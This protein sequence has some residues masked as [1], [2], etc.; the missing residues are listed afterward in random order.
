VAFGDPP[1]CDQCREPSAVRIVTIVFEGLSPPD[2]YL[3]RAHAPNVEAPVA[4]ER[5]MLGARGDRGE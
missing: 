5:A 3:C 2:Q 1:P 4:T